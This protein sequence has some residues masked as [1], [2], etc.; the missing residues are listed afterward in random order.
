MDAVNGAWTFQGPVLP[1]RHAN[2]GI[3]ISVSSFVVSVESSPLLSRRR[4]KITAK[5]QGTVN[6][7]NMSL[8]T[9]NTFLMTSNSVSSSVGKKGGYPTCL[10]RGMYATRSRAWPRTS[11]HKVT[12]CAADAGDNKRA[13]RLGLRNTY[14]STSIDAQISRVLSGL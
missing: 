8:M 12:K 4:H 5:Q 7:Q 2:A 6:K 3:R 14:T 10:L 9:S 11:R 1:P 13:D